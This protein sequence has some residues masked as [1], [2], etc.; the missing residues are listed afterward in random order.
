[1]Q[2]RNESNFIVD[3]GGEMVTVEITANKIADTAI[4][5]LPPSADLQQVSQSPRTY[6]LKANVEPGK[7]LFGEITCDFTGGPD[8]ASFQVKVSSL[9]SG[10]F[11][12]PT[13]VKSDP[14]SA[15]PVALNFEGP[16]AN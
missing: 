8:D 7:T 12:G 6:R 16:Q 14:G 13:I 5:T 9:G 10:P 11:D 15:E 3:K 2:K 4:Y 1:M